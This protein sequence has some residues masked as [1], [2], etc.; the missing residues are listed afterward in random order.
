MARPIHDVTEVTSNL[1]F[2]WQIVNIATG[3]ITLL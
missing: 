1:I 3:V 2:N